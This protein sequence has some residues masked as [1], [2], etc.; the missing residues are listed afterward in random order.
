MSATAASSATESGSRFIQKVDAREA[1]SITRLAEPLDGDN[2][3]VWRERIHRVFKVCGVLSYVEGAGVPPPNKETH[4][5]DF[6]AW[7][8]NDSYAQC[9]ISN[10][11]TANQMMNVSRLITAHQMW[12]SLSAVHE[13]RGHQYAI[14]LL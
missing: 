1:A 8:F 9:L 5:E 7:E 4:P 11:I 2:W 14:A 13:S 12:A 10:N 6:E 3:T